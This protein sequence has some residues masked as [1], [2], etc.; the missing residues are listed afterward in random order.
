MTDLTAWPHL[1]NNDTAVDQH[2]SW[3]LLSINQLL[4]LMIHVHVQ[5]YTNSMKKERLVVLAN[6]YKSVTRSSSK[7][8]EYRSSYAQWKPVQ[9]NFKRLLQK[10]LNHGMGLH[11]CT[12]T[13]PNFFT[14]QLTVNK[15]KTNGEEREKSG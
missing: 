13:T 7:M 3:R 2:I 11:F 1:L 8:K 10:T 6:K 15:V 4:S 14:N 12:A 5:V 9:K